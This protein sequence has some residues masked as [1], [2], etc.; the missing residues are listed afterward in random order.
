[1]EKKIRNL[2]ASRVKNIEG[3][4]WRYYC[5][6]ELRVPSGTNSGALR[7]TT[8]H[9]VLECLINKRHSST[10]NLLKKAKTI[11]ASPSIER[12]VKTYLRKFELLDSDNPMAQEEDHFILCDQM[13][14]VGLTNKFLG[15]K[16]SSH[17]VSELKFKIDNADP[18][19]TMLGFIDKT[20]FTG[21]KNIKITDYKTSKRRFE[22]KELSYNPQAMSYILAAHKEWPNLKNVSI[23]FMFL[24]FPDNPIQEFSYTKAELEGFEHYLATLWEKINNFTEQDGLAD[25][26]AYQ[27]WPK[28]DEGFTGKLMCGRAEYPGQL[29]K[30]GSVMWHCSAKF[31]FDYYQGIDE[32]GGIVSTG[33]TRKELRKNPKVKTTKKVH[34]GGCPAFS[35]GSSC[36][37]D[38]KK[39][40]SDDFGF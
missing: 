24:R 11:T 1:M 23:D 8:C 17:P 9:A 31:A 13:I 34:Y 15:D 10:L 36:S 39:K 38:K 30:D 40:K 5:D 33:K 18:R 25:L 37:G 21:K 12:K 32:E 19:Y 7:G 4:S 14:I 20:T 22:G 16:G 29:K 35:R 2:S 6:Y 28:K 27:D 26:A 3:C